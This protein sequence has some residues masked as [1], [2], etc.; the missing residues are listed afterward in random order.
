MKQCLFRLASALVCVVMASS[1]AYAQG[2]GSVAP[3]SGVVVDTSGA[4]VPG[5]SV[6]VKN[7]GTGASY[8]TVTNA[9][10][11]FTVPALEPGTYTVTISL[12]GFKQAV[13]K[14]NKL[15]T[16]TP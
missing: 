6:T 16:A 12:T 4:P 3:L 13:L 2:G 14:G 7:E 9:Q 10:G 15:L 11:N 1:L 5:A 8:P